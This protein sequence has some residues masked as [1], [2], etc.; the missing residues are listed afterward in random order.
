MF[1]E[2]LLAIIL[3]ENI[4]ELVVK[5]QLF[6]PVR[7]VVIYFNDF[8]GK[9]IRCGQCLSL[10]TSIGVVF[11]VDVSYNF[12]EH[13]YLNLFLTALIV[14]RLSNYLHNFCDKCLDKYYDCRYINSEKDSED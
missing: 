12:T 14:H 4:T 8:L 11:L 9:L 7:R 5:S 6:E 2:I 3:V 13:S 10:W 1:V